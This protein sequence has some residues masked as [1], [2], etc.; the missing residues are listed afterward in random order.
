MGSTEPQSHVDWTPTPSEARTG[1]VP[2]DPPSSVVSPESTV[3]EFEEGC[4]L[5]DEEAAVAGGEP[6]PRVPWDVSD[7]HPPRRT[8]VVVPLPRRVRDVSP[9]VL[10]TAVHVH[11]RLHPLRK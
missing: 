3:E 11:D 4:H 1:P 9:P 6:T 5:G 10:E 7:V 2:G 8:P